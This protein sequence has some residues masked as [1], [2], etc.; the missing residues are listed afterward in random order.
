[1]AGDFKTILFGFVLFSLFSFLILTAVAYQGELYSKDTSDFSN[2]LDLEKFNESIRTVAETGQSKYE[3]SKSQSIF[4]VVA[5]IVVT[6][7]F[8]IANSLYTMIT[9]PFV[10]LA[11][12]MVNVLQIPE[13][14]VNVLLG[15]LFI[16]ILLSIWYLIKVGE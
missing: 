14:V 11:N 7:M 16:S 2:S 9:V 12:I 5:G 10:L 8:G 3:E 4:S 6:G 13:I 15:L 1:M